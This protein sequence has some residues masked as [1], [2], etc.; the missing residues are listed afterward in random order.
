MA[1]PAP[2]TVVLRRS[3]FI[4]VS[5]MRRSGSGAVTMSALRGQFARRLLLLLWT[6]SISGVHGV[7]SE[8][9]GNIPSVALKRLKPHAAQQ[10][11]SVRGNAA[12]QDR[13]CGP[14]SGTSVR[15]HRP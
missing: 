6:F 12:S 2:T 14:R 8:Q 10:G 15:V 13:F 9:V 3:R 7:G 1:M 5:K 4:S 11:F